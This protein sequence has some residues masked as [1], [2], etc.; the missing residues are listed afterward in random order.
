MNRYDIFAEIAPGQTRIGFFDAAGIIQDVWLC[1]DDQPD[2]TGS[3]H[4]ARVE[5]VFAGKTG[6]V[7]GWLMAR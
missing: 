5:Q 3:V 7:G 4:Q 6:R 2:L 1:R